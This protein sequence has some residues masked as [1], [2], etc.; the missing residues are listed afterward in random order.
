MSVVLGLIIGGKVHAFL[1][2]ITAAI[3]VSLCA[4]GEMATRIARVAGAFGKSA[5]SIGIVIAMA[6]VFALDWIGREKRA[7][8]DGDAG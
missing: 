7:A 8:P 4:D 1:A 2:L 3:V 6:A 5:G